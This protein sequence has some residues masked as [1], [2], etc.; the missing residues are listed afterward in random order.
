[1]IIW[2]YYDEDCTFYIEEVSYEWNNLFN[3]DQ[4]GATDKV[5]ETWNLPWEYSTKGCFWIIQLSLDKL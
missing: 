2:K 4:R 5:V 3:P 1:L